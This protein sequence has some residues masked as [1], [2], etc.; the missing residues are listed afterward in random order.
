[1]PSNPPQPLPDQLWGQQWR[2][3]SLPAD[4]IAREMATRPIPHCS[5]PD[6]LLPLQL[7]LASTAVIPGVVIDGG[8][9]SLKLAQWVTQVQPQEL[10]V[11][12]AE[13]NGLIL[14]TTSSDRWILATFADPEVKAAG[15]RY[16]A[17]CTASQGLHFLLIQPDDSGITYSGF[18]LLQ[19]SKPA[20]VGLLP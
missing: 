13:L 20:V 2:F 19:R 16:L 11:V 8:R 3:A 12:T 10:S 4:A 5:I 1:M 15:D 6:A 9:Q 7:G 18:W 14:E 17:R